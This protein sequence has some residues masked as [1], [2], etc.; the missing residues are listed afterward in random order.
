[1]SR[2]KSLN[3]DHWF[4]PSHP[5]LPDASSFAGLLNPVIHILISHM[6][7]LRHHLPVGDRL[8]TQLVDGDLSVPATMGTD[9]P[10]E[11]SLCHRPFPFSLK[12]DIDDLAISIHGSP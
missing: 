3:L 1:M 8:A 5:S 4:E 10:P 9:Q 2:N 7:Y 6:N 11:K 12:V